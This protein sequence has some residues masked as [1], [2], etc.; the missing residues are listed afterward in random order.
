MIYGKCRMIYLLRRYDIISVPTYAKR[1]SS[2][3]QISYPEGI[4]PVP[5]GTDIIVKKT[6]FVY[7]TKE[8]FYMV[9]EMG[10]EPTRRLPHA[11]QTCLST[12][13]NTPAFLDAGLL[14]RVGAHLS[15][16]FYKSAAT[17]L[18][19][20]YLRTPAIPLYI[21]FFPDIRGSL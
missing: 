9:Q 17:N 12:Y 14:Y 8:V 19:N 21:R 16:L 6:S 15:T 3:K 2:A 1:I 4:S 13:S 5:Q 11:P 18:Q 10:L 20:F 7:Q